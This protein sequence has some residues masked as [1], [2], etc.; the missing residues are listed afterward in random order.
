MFS[1]KQH[2][3][4]FFKNSQFICR[5][6]RQKQILILNLNAAKQF[7]VSRGKEKN[8]PHTFIHTV[9]NSFSLLSVTTG[10]T[11][12]HKCI[13]FVYNKLSMML[14]LRYRV[15]HSWTNFKEIHLFTSWFLVTQ[16]CTSQLICTFCQKGWRFVLPT[17]T[18]Q[19][20][21][22]HL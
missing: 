20:E 19:V 2:V 7:M 5:E 4:F 9:Q 21:V 16:I 15:L 17:C 12:K 18:V 11:P 3:F 13:F 1:S 8:N 14:C 10:I 22:S 6:L